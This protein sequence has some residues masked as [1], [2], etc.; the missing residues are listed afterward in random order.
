MSLNMPV[1]TD[2]SAMLCLYVFTLFPR[3]KK[4]GA[5]MLVIRTLMYVHFAAVLYLTLMP[6]LAALPFIGEDARSPMNTIPFIDVRLQRGDYMRQIALNTLMLLPYGFLRPLTKERFCFFGT[7]LRAFLIS[8]TIEFLQ[9]HFGR[10][11]DVTDLI[12][13]TAGVAAGYVISA[14]LRPMTGTVLKL[15]NKERGFT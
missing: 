10:T 9:P 5:D 7:V 3:W 14:C 15:M 11:A 13:N 4:Q 6:V 2:L 1:I 8:L 12:T